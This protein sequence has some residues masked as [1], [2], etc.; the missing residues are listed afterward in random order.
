GCGLNIGVRIL[1][2][3]TERPQVRRRFGAGT[4][5]LQGA[6]NAP[7]GVVQRGQRLGPCAEQGFGVAD[8]NHRGR[9]RTRQPRV[10]PEWT[11]SQSSAA[12]LASA[13]G[14]AA[15]IA[16]IAGFGAIAETTIAGAGR[17]L[18]YGV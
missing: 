15:R 16:R 14:L 8:M 3:E 5:L 13:A 17:R 11:F 4:P 2:G 6:P 10:P 1:G 9:R 18:G 12:R 7:G